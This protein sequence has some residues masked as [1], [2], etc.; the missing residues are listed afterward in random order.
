MQK[1]LLQSVTPELNATTLF[2]RLVDWF[3]RNDWHY[4]EHRGEEESW[5]S[6]RVSCD[7]GKWR[8]IAKANEEMRQV[9]FFAVLDINIPEDR[10]MAVAEFITRANFS[11]RIGFFEMDWRDGEIRFNVS[12]AIADGELT[13]VQIEQAVD[14]V[15]NG[16][17]RYFVALMGV[18][19][20]G[21][22]PLA[23]LDVVREPM[24]EAADSADEAKGVIH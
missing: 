18:V 23:A 7:N 12:F 15:L 2:G 22:E 4:D 8:L 5:L 6:A 16:M 13:D 14:G 20:G 3:D 1:N 10:R 19:Y 21:R 17:D 11:K 24:A 9:Y